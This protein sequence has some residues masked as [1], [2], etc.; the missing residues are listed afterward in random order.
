[1]KAYTISHGDGLDKLKIIDKASPIMKDDQLRIR[2]HATSL[3]Y[4]DYL[5]ATGAIKVSEGRIPMSDAA[6]EVIEK[7]SSVNEFEIGDK[8][9]PLFF[10]N[11]T[12]GPADY[13]KV[14]EISGESVDGYMAKES[15]LHSWQLTK[16]PEN[17][18]YAEAAVLPT[19]AL[20]AWNA[21]VVN[22]SVKMGDKVLIEGTGGM[23]L[24]AL[25]FA[26]AAGAEVYATTSSEEKAKRLLALGVKQV[27][28]YRDDAHWGKSIFKA[29]GGGMDHVLDVG[30]GSTMKQSIEACKIG[31]HVHAIGILGNGRKGEITF[32]KLFFKFI[33][34]EGLAVGSRKMQEEMVKAINV[35][36]IK[37]II[38][39]IFGFDEL[40]QAFEYQASGRQFGKIV[41][42]W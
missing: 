37:P 4:H 18:S 33:K 10:P 11:W 40:A 32:P 17:Y 12:D 6:G 2:W 26:K 5:V 9:M 36:N 23:S 39:K 8:V 24:C 28:N 3:N 7:G 31:A 27:F 15:C 25:Q 14:A 42:E 29:S 38:D 1:M 35:T 19:A 16:I 21:L 22:G 34:M 41:L 20:T 13:H 30:G